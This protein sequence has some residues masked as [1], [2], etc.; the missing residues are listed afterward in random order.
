[1]TQRYSIGELADLAGVSRRT[2]HFYVQR[3]L[4]DPPLGLGRG[5]HYDER[6]LSQIRRVRELQRL[7]VPLASMAGESLEAVTAR[8]AAAQV[9]PGAAVD[10]WAG[11]GAIAGAQVVTPVVRIRAGENVTVEVI[12]GAVRVTPALVADLTSAVSSVMSRHRGGGAHGAAAEP[13]EEEE[14]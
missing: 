3:R 1:M 6:H 14:P 9:P 4:I 10:V 11:A 12:A 13:G 5:R 8:D 7:G 2:V